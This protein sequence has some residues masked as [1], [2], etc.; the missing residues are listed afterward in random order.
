M[1][2]GGRWSSRYDMFGQGI[3]S[4]KSLLQE[5]ESPWEVTLT[6]PTLEAF[7]ILPADWPERYSLS[8]SV[9]R[10]CKMTLSPSYTN[11][12]FSSMEVH[13]VAWPIQREDSHGEFQ[14]GTLGALLST[15]TTSKN[16]GKYRS[17]TKS[18]QIF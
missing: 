6:E 5:R 17:I 16:F 13:V 8:Q 15:A 2:P 12:F 4:G 14:E 10:S 18:R 3:F 11:S 1:K 9:G 7:E